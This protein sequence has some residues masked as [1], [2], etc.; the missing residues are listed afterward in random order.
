MNFFYNLVA[1][2]VFRTYLG[3]ALICKKADKVVMIPAEV[4]WS[5]DQ[6][7]S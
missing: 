1:L 7:N 3:I 2:T 6:W 5:A 4:S